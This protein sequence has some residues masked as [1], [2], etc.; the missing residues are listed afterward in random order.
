MTKTMYM[1]M[2]N[3]KP[4]FYDGCQIAYAGHGLRIP[5]HLRSSLAVIRKEHQKSYLWR[6]KQGWADN[7]HYGYSRVKVGGAQ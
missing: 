6:E 7:L 3:G 1:H 4:A 2:L 5:D